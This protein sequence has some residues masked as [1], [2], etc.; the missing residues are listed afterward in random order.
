LAHPSRERSQTSETGKALGVKP[1]SMV[2]SFADSEVA[3]TK[4][5]RVVSDD[6]ADAKYRSFSPQMEDLDLQLIEVRRP[7][8]AEYG[9]DE[10]SL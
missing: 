10:A 7:I 1:E 5:D 8:G 3:R 4:D 6:D 9:E 2:D